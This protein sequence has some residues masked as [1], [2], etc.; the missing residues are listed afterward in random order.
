[1]CSNVVNFV[2]ISDLKSIF[3]LDWY[4]KRIL[5]SKWRP[6]KALFSGLFSKFEVFISLLVSFSKYGALY[7]NWPFL[8]DLSTDKSIMTNT[9]GQK[10]YLQIC[11]SILAKI[12]AYLVIF[13]TA[14][15]DR[16]RKSTKVLW[17]FEKQELR[18]HLAGEKDWLSEEITW[19]WN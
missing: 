15:P 9:G 14:L 2:L 10:R 18:I 5:R 7:Q 16:R 19:N 13:V 8:K 4:F 12:W 11:F 1:M 6:P 17:S 3:D